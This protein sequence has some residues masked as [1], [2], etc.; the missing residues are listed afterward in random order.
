MTYHIRCDGDI[1]CYRYVS[2]MIVVVVVVVVVVDYR[3]FKQVS[4]R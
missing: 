1:Y 2:D 4:G 3:L